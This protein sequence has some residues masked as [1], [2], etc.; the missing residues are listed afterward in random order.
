MSAPSYLTM[1]MMRFAVAL[2]TAFEALQR[3]PMRGALTGFGILVGVSAVTIVITLGE[4][5]ERAVQQRIEKLGENLITIKARAAQASG[6]G[7]PASTLAPS[8]GL[9][10]VPSSARSGRAWDSSWR[11]AGSLPFSRG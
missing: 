2:R 4:G 11:S 3:N 9:S 8:P 5:A 7:W 1:L 6:A 10:L